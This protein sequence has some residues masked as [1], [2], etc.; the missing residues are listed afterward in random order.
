MSI[1]NPWT[2]YAVVLAVAILIYYTF[3]GWK[4]YKREIRSLF[5]DKTKNPH[6]GPSSKGYQL[7]LSRHEEQ[8][9]DHS[10]GTE[11]A[12]SQDEALFT[13]VQA[14]EEHLITEIEEAHQKGYNKQDLIQMLQ[15]ILKEY[16]AMKGTSFQY[17]VNKRID[18]ECAKYGLLHLNEDDKGE[19]WPIA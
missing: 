9:A 2:A 15:M 18:A 6:A 4:Y 11:Q 12:A 1:S 19:V 10:G 17:T 5:K 3:V 16:G 14:L 13:Q 8:E 7:R